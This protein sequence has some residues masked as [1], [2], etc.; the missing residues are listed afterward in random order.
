MSSP[1]DD[2]VVIVAR[3]LNE[4]FF[5]TSPADHF[6]ARAGML[7]DLG[8][9]LAAEQETTGSGTFTADLLARMPGWEADAQAGPGGRRQDAAA[10]TV[11]A[12]MLAHLSLIHI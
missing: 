12:F 9:Q 5:E 3:Q 11:E 7:A 8:D 10:L 1:D 4:A 6:R 2:R